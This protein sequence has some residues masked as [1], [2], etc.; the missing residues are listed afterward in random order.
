VPSLVNQAR[1]AREFAI[2]APRLGVP[3]NFIEGFDQPW[4]RRLEGAMGGYWGLFDSAGEQ[5]F[6]IRGAVIEDIHWQRGWLAAAL[7]A[8]AA[9]LALSLVFAGRRSGQPVGASTSTSAVPWAQPALLAVAAGISAGAVAMAQWSYMTLW[10]RTWIE[11][12]VTAV[13]ALAALVIWGVAVVLASRPANG[14]A[15]PVDALHTA[16]A[17][18]RLFLLFGAAVMMV[19]LAFDARYRG[20]PWQLYCLPT[21]SFLILARRRLPFWRVGLEERM[22]ASV[23]VLGGAAVAYLEGWANIHALTFVALMIAMASLAVRADYRWLKVRTKTSAPVNAPTAA[24][25]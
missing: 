17:Y 7:A 21:V 12:T 22:L 13:Y 25:S 5:K 19:L 9:L 20:F 1:F 24:N 3:Y 23:I 18:L 16:F 10:N 8:I 15:L 4:K 6:P 11:W 14:L 2:A